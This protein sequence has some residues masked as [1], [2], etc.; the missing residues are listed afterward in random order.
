MLAS[1]RRI[2]DVNVDIDEW[3]KQGDQHD[4]ENDMPEFATAISTVTVQFTDGFS[5]RAKKH[6]RCRR[7]RR[8]RGQWRRVRIRRDQGHRGCLDQLL[9]F[10]THQGEIVVHGIEERVMILLR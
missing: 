1:R 2:F 10:G 6:V 7:R 5:G 8:R 4:G 3:N 9:D